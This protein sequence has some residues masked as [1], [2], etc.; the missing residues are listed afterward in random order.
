MRRTARVQRGVVGESRHR[1]V[2]HGLTQLADLLLGLGIRLR[3]RRLVERHDH[4]WALGLLATSNAVVSIALV[5]VVAALSRQALVFPSLGPTAFL[6]IYRPHAIV[7][8]PRNTICGHLVGAGSG[9]VALATMGLIHHG[10]A[11]HHMTLARVAAAAISLGLTTGGM[12]W[13]DVPHPPAAATTLIISLGFL[14]DP[15]GVGVLMLGVLLLVGQGVLINRFAGIDYP[16]WAARERV[17]TEVRRAHRLDREA[18]GKPHSE[19]TGM[20]YLLFLDAVGDSRLN[21]IAAA[22]LL[23]A[24]GDADEFTADDHEWTAYVTVQA[25]DLVEAAHVVEER[26]HEA[27]HAAGLDDWTFHCYEVRPTE[28]RLD[29]QSSRRRARR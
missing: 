10:A 24:L 27:D 28:I 19:V 17:A 11:P 12:I 7:S 25:D 4:R 13:L 8:S 6:L 20:S 29:G 21:R 9:L 5:A 22:R 18:R 1:V 2:D 16:L 15:T 23:A 14:D 3:W 26:V